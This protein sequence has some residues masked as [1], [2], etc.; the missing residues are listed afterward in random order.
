MLFIDKLC[1]SYETIE[2][3]GLEVSKIIS[4][5]SSLTNDKLMTVIKC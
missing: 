5:F 4:Y 3:V 2:D 1:F